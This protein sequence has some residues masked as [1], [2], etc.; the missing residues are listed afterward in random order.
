[1]FV[2]MMTMIIMMMIKMIVEVNGFFLVLVLELNDFMFYFI[3]FL[4]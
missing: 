1:M 4:L 2:M 3:V